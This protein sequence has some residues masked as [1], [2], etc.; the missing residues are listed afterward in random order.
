M[1]FM[2]CCIF[3]QVFELSKCHEYQV[4]SKQSFIFLLYMS[5]QS[6]KWT[7]EHTWRTTV[8]TKDVKPCILIAS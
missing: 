5:P 2:H 4:Q 8:E 6:L 1:I 3:A 7:W